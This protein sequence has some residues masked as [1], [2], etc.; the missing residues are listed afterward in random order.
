MNTHSPAKVMFYYNSIFVAGVLVQRADDAD[1]FGLHLMD[2]VNDGDFQF[3][4]GPEE[5]EA[6]PTHF[7]GILCMGAYVIGQLKGHK[8]GKVQLTLPADETSSDE[9]A[10]PGFTYQFHQWTKAGDI[11]GM[12]SEPEMK[13]L[14][15][16]SVLWRGHPKEVDFGAIQALKTYK[17]SER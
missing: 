13:V 7:N 10:F 15:G 11:F 4:N 5:G 16:D 3:V 12:P 14:Y 17:P 9:E 1:L 8:I 2:I 6:V